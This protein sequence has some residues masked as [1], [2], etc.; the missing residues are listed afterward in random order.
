MLSVS[1]VD[2]KN[3]C[4]LQLIFHLADTFLFQLKDKENAYFY[5]ELLLLYLHQNN[6]KTP[7]NLMRS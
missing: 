7:R 1:Y 5:F 2:R 4:Y 6:Y 3:Q